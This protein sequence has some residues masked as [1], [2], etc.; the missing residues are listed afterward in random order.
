[1][2]QMYWSAVRAGDRLM[3]EKIVQDW[4]GI[5]VLLSK[6]TYVEVVLNSI[7]KEYDELEYTALEELRRNAYVRFNCG[8]DK[9]GCP[10]YCLAM[11]ETQELINSWT[12]KLPLGSKLEDWV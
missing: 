10:F 3:Q 4:L 12:K 9:D 6:P 2:F 7:D 11:D 8:S 5:F 1:M